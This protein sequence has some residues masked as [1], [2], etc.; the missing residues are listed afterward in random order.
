MEYLYCMRLVR[1][2]QNGIPNQN[3]FQG[4]RIKAN[5]I[6]F[7]KKIIVKTKNYSPPVDKLIRPLTKSMLKEF[8][9][10]TSP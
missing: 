9:I 5:I 7:E 10:S 8:F 1:F 3:S 6:F 2:N 4:F